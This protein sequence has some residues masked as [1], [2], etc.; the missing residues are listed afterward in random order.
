MLDGHINK[1][2]QQ[3]QD[4]FKTIFAQMITTLLNVW[5]VT[6]YEV[7]GRITSL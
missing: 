7:L 1:I 4:Y 2:N 5:L 6:F 3:L